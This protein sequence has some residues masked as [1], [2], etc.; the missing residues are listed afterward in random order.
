M[1]FEI[2]FFEFYTRIGKYFLEKAEI[3]AII[4]WS[5][6]T[7]DCVSQWYPSWYGKGHV[8]IYYTVRNK[9]LNTHLWVCH[10]L[11][12][13]FMNFTDYQNGSIKLT[14]TQN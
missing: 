1:L 12:N 4:P 3:P 7:L 10:S 9:I 5:I 14:V 2:W 8:L 6:S 11:K 13:Y